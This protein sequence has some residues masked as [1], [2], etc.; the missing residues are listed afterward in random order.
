MADGTK[1]EW[2]DATWNPLTGCSVVSPGCR[3]CY[4]MKLAGT[5]LQHHESRVGL[6]QPSK[7]GPV[8]TGEVRFNEKWLD[9]PLRWRESRKIFV[10]AHSDLFHEKALALW[11]LRI[12]AAMGKASHHIY[13][14]LTKRPAAM[15]E[16][17]SG[18]YGCGEH[19]LADFGYFDPWPWPHVWLGTSIEDRERLWRL[20]ELRNTPAHVRFLSLEP[21]LEDL[22]ELDLTGI[23]QVIV[24][25]ESGRGARPM[26][27]EWVRDIRDQCVEQG[28]PFFFKQW[29]EW[30]PGVNAIGPVLRTEQT[31]DWWNGKW[32]FS[33]ITPKQAEEL[34]RDDEPAL[35]RLGKKQAGRHL[36]GVLHDGV[37]A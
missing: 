25:G 23:H 30:A 3:H 15:R 18:A 2:T 5:R 12:F 32:D 17:L 19:W 8:W 4:A 11:R 20:D 36:D 6:T 34:H 26:H 29:G 21:L 9:Q 14:V 33:S 37:P 24:G 13:Q 7:N 16:E 28:V 1:I 10:C 22:G 27:P 35:Y 31:A